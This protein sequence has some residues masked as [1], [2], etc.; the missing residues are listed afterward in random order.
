[1]TVKKTFIQ[2]LKREILDS[3]LGQT[4][5]A[6]FMLLTTAEIFNVS[7]YIIFSTYWLTAIYIILKSKQ[8]YRYSDLLYIQFGIAFNL[9]I[10]IILSCLYRI[11]L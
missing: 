8:I 5:L 11:F 3:I 6:L 7:Y 4:F 10:L 9:C 2:L 1:M